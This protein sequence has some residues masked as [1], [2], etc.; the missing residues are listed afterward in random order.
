MPCAPSQADEQLRAETD[1]FCDEEDA[2][3]EDVT[4][5]HHKNV[6]ASW[7]D[8]GLGHSAPDEYT[9]VTESQQTYDEQEYKEQICT[10]IEEAVRHRPDAFYQETKQAGVVDSLSR[11][12]QVRWIRQHGLR[13]G[14][15]SNTVALAVNYFDRYL[16][17]WKVTVRGLRSRSA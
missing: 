6:V 9:E 8:G 14:F 4:M 1:L 3:V 2:L 13:L 12:W 11:K 5:S 10:K 17:L 15:A 7:S 16:S